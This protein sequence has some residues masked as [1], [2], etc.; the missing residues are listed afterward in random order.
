MI[1]IKLKQLLAQRAYDGER[2]TIVEL[3]QRTGISRTTLQRISNTPGYKTTTDHLD[4][5]CNA[6]G[7][8]LHELVEFV[9][10][11]LHSDRS[12]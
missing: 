2:L 5:L 7:C 8:D 11:E 12:E 6:L 9:P 3:A 1:K 4:R 10:D